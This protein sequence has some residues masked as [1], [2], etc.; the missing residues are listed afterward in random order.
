LG[1]VSQDPITLPVVLF[2]SQKHTLAK[3]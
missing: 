2:G 3:I 1:D